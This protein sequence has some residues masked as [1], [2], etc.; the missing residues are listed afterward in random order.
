MGSQELRIHLLRSADIH[1]MHRTV[2]PTRKN[3]DKKDNTCLNK[4]IKS[5]ILRCWVNSTLRTASTVHL[6]RIWPAKISADG[7][8][9]TG[10]I[11]VVFLKEVV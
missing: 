7:E 8:Q 10:V 5:A 6:T 2:E 3:K 9:P 1:L 4:T 11:G